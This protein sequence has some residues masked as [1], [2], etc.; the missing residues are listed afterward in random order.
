MSDFQKIEVEN[1]I[2]SIFTEL[3]Q[4]LELTPTETRVVMTG[5]K[6]LG[7]GKPSKVLSKL[8]SNNKD[9]IENTFNKYF[10]HKYN[11][12][13]RALLRTEFQHQLDLS[14]KEIP[15]GGLTI[16]EIK[17]LKSP[18]PIPTELPPKAGEKELMEYKGVAGP[19]T[20]SITGTMVTEDHTSKINPTQAI[21]G[22]S[23]AAVIL[24]NTEGNKAE[25][26]DKAENLN[27]QKEVNAPIEHEKNE[28][29]PENLAQNDTRDIEMEQ[30]LPNMK[31]RNLL[32]Y[33]SNTPLIGS[34]FPKYSIGYNPEQRT[35]NDLQI[36][37][38]NTMGS[39]GA[40]T[41]DHNG[42][43]VKNMTPLEQIASSNKDIL[44][45]DYATP[46]GQKVIAQKLANIDNIHNEIKHLRDAL[47]PNNYARIESTQRQ[48]AIQRSEPMQRYS[49][50]QLKY[51][52]YLKFQQKMMGR[53]LNPI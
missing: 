38:Q 28:D 53:N 36:S 14:I 45:I 1:A 41:I 46:A 47:L 19:S 51:L 20:V 27:E 32:N 6:D 24:N 49:H 52:E 48:N 25:L 12:E 4:K 16:K 31:N 13:T 15:K 35:L 7:N 5:M 44:N 23:T 30:T 21:P 2:K 11:T 29:V 22:V 17:K 40:M 33:L 43:L 18:N 8:G 42:N 34:N 39:S 9:I 26:S 10:G 50:S 3:E 37:Q